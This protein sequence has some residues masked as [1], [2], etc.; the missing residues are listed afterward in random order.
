LQWTFDAES[1]ESSLVHKDRK[2]KFE[3]L[4][5]VKAMNKRALWTVLDTHFTEV[6]KLNQVSIHI[7]S[8]T[9]RKNRSLLEF[10]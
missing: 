7:L 3:G 4:G 1:A 10:A 2:E 9:L 6:E 5:P 8:M